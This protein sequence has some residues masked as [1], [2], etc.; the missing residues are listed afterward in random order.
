MLGMYIIYILSETDGHTER[1]T[2]RK[3]GGGERERERERERQREREREREEREGGRALA[4]QRINKK[5][6]PNDLKFT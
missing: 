3:K 5:V 1:H 4:R 6:T 2:H